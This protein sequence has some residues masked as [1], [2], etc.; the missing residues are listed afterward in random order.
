MI[1]FMIK[2]KMYILYKKTP[3]IMKGDLH[4]MNADGKY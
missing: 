1:I 2:I 4:C 3:L